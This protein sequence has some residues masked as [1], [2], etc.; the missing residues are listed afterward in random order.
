MFLSLLGIGAFVLP[1]ILLVLAA[2]DWTLRQKR[3]KVLFQIPPFDGL[4]GIGFQEG[5]IYAQSKKHFTEIVPAAKI[6]GFLI[7]ADVHR[8]SDNELL[9]S[10]KRHLEF[11]AIV[12]KRDLDRQTFKSK[13]KRLKELGIV[14]SKKSPSFGGRY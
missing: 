3:R 6:D 14:Y 9:H 7:K 12:E 13:Q 5:K 8:E 2:M 11:S 10:K 1:I 4:L